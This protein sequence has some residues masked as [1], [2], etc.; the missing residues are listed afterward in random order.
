MNIIMSNFNSINIFS[1][2]YTMPSL[3]MIVSSDD[4][5]PICNKVSIDELTDTIHVMQF[6]E[7]THYKC[8]H[9]MVASLAVD[10][11]CRVKV[12]LHHHCIIYIYH[13]I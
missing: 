10:R 13:S 12:S 6:Q 3:N 1:I 2:T 7:L 11:D 8:K 5:S 9:Y 4:D